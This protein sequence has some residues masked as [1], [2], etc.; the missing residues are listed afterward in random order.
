MPLLLMVITRHGCYE[1][2]TIITYQSFHLIMITAHHSSVIAVIMGSNMPD[3]IVIT[4]SS[5]K[6][7]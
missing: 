7:I 5:L 3:P 1:M 4:L 6:S 2:F